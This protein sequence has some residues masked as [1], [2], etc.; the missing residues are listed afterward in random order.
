MSDND[1]LDV[2]LNRKQLAGDYQTKEVE[3][4][5]LKIQNS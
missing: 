5:V 3:A 4:V 2:L 1:L